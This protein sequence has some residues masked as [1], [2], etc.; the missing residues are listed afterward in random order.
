[1]LGIYVYRIIPFLILCSLISVPG[2]W[3][4]SAWLMK[5]E[6]SYTVHVVAI[7]TCS[8]PFFCCQATWYS[9]LMGPWQLFSRL[10]QPLPIR[11]KDV[12]PP[13][14]KACLC[15]SVNQFNPINTNKLW[16]DLLLS[17]RCCYRLTFHQYWVTKERLVG[18]VQGLLSEGMQSY[19][20]W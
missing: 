18:C 7:Q 20:V 3:G 9:I 15:T 5:C 2:V 6:A 19:S 8:T 1:M 16:V 11:H 14:H 10:V 12:H 4:F 13:V 17:K